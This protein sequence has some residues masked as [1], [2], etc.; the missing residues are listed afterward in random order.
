MTERCIPLFSNVAQESTGWILVERTFSS[1]RHSDNTF[2]HSFKSHRA[3]I[4][5]MELLS[6]MSDSSFTRLLRSLK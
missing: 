1:S 5:S 6:V 2:I 4:I 3:K